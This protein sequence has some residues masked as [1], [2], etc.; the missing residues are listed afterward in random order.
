MEGVASRLQPEG[1]STIVTCRL[2]GSDL[3][4]RALPIACTGA[5]SSNGLGL[6]VYDV[7]QRDASPQKEFVMRVAR[8]TI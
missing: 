7:H 5:N 8:V 3:F 2:H 6:I 1:S 4:N